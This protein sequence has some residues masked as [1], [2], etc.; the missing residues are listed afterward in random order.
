MVSD[1]V[2]L[3]DVGPTVLDYALLG[4]IEG[5]VGQSLCQQVEGAAR[6]DRVVP[7]FRYDNVSIRNG[8]FRLVRYEDGSTQFYDLQSDM[9]NLHDLGESHLAYDENREALIEVCEQYGL[10]LRD[11][12]TAVR[13]AP[14]GKTPS[15]KPAAVAVEH[16]SQPESSKSETIK[17][18]LAA[19][20][21]VYQDY[22][23]LKR[24][25]NYYAAQIG[26]ENLFI[27][28]HG[29]DE[30][31]RKIAADANVMN[32]PRDVSMWKFDRRRWRMMSQ[33]ASGMLEFYNW[34]LV[35][36]VDEIV[37]IDPQISRS[38]PTYLT[39]R[40]S[41]LR[42]SPRSI[43]PF[44]LN[45]VHVPEEEPLPIEDG[46]KVLSRRRFFYPSR[47][48]SKPCL[49]REPA[50][51][52]PG[53]HRNN[54]GRRVLSD[55]LYLLHLKM[56]DM[57]EMHSRAEHQK[58]MISV[59]AEENSDHKAGHVWM[60][61]ESDY[62]KIMSSMVLGE[63]DISLRHIRAAMMNQKER[64]TNQFVWGQFENNTLFMVPPRFADVF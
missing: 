38:L 35:S 2:A 60:Q 21:M 3:L 18:P 6:P 47:V 58:R 25:Y 15:G 44:G 43:S 26:A 13:N 29:N 14:S 4:P 10:S 48:Y 28:S 62:E 5:C 11:R 53:G 24:W 32:V 23:F 42:T 8:K 46:V 30:E 41:D 51:F 16:P 52:G 54:L 27:F 20:T 50:M 56:Y 22:A 64:Y 59:A 34:M 57:T 37:V 36:D 7:S 49:F 19:V 31:H 40:F 63:E 45:I 12:A 61:T 33:F 55:D 9:W 39:D 17:R 1:P